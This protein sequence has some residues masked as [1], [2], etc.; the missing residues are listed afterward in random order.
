MNA[1][2]WIKEMNGCKKVQFFASDSEEVVI[3]D[4]GKITKNQFEKRTPGLYK[5]EYQGEGMLALNSKVYHF[6]KYDKN[7]EIISKTSRNKG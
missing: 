1:F 6:W 3:F 2:F 5:F 4:G 7:S